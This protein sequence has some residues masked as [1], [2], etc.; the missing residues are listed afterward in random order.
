MNEISWLNISLIEWIGYLAS[1]I[2]LISLSLS[3]LVKLRIFNMFGA[4]IFSFYGFYIG[5]LPVGIMNLIIVFFNIYYLRFMLF[6]TEL[7]DVV[8][9]NAGDEFLKKYIAYHLKDIENFFPDYVD[10]FNGNEKVLLALRDAKVAGVF[11][12][13]KVNNRYEIVLDYV[14]PEYRDYKTGRFLLSKYKDAFKDVDCAN[15][16][17]TTG[18]ERHIS[19][20]NKIGFKA[21]SDKNEF[22]L[23]L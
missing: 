9:V 8:E 13:G 10:N 3:S 11:M 12:V 7:F 16:Y 6:K 23:A 1:T 21:G 17:C 5:A 19:Y 22:V 20:L 14:T 4:A 18:N 15:L 2:V